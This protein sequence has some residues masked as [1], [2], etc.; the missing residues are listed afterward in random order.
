MKLGSPLARWTSTRHL[1]RVQPGGDRSAVITASDI[2]SFSLSGA[3]LKP[4]GLNVPGGGIVP[5]PPSDQFG[6]FVRLA[7][8]RFRPAS[9]HAGEVHRQ[10]GGWHGSCRGWGNPLLNQ[11]EPDVKSFAFVAA[12]RCLRG[13]RVRA[14]R[15]G[16][17]RSPESPWS[18]HEPTS[19]SSATASAAFRKPT[20]SWRCRGGFD[21]GHSSGLYVGNWNS[22]VDSGMYNGANL[23]NGLYGGWKRPST[24]ASASTSARS[25]TTTRAPARVARPGSATPSCYIGGS[26]GRC[27]PS[28]NYAVSDFFSAPDSRARATWTSAQLRL[29]QQLGRRRAPTATSISG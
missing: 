22:N 13:A 8:P 9:R 4:I 15:A 24:T 19:A 5:G 29:R 27:R 11:P 20:R 1:R 23:R 7:G 28:Y 6:A 21:L 12:G 18:L 2:G 3:F 25:T 26:W 17:I 14:D 16:R 10:D